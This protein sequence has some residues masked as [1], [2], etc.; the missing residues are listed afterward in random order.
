MNYELRV[1]IMG[2]PRTVNRMS[3]RHWRSRVTEAKKW[4][5]AVF[6]AV[7]WQGPKE[8]LKKAR[9][10]LTRHSMI[11]PDFDNLASSFKYI[12]DGLVK[13]GV[14]QDDKPSVIGSPSFKWAK[15][16]PREGFIEVF[17]EDMGASNGE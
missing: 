15:A 8:P 5:R 13:C 11:E 3:G 12:L 2:L 17:V 10:T 14:I 7:G 4:H 16:K 1:K 6:L 9:L